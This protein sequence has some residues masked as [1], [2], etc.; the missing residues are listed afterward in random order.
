MRSRKHSTI[1]NILGLSYM[2]SILPFLKHV[3]GWKEQSHDWTNDEIAELYR[4][5]HAL[6]RANISVDTDRGITDEGDPWFVFCRRD[7]EVI[8]HIAR[9]D[10]LYHL[11]SPALPQPLEGPTFSALTRAFVASAPMAPN[12]AAASGVALHPAALLSLLV[13]SIFFSIDHLTG[14]PDRAQAAVVDRGHSPATPKAQYVQAILN[15]MVGAINPPEA[16]EVM[17]FSLFAGQVALAFVDFDLDEGGG[18]IAAGEGGAGEGGVRDAAFYHVDANELSSTSVAGANSTESSAPATPG[19]SLHSH[20][21]VLIAANAAT[22]GASSPPMIVGSSHAGGTVPL[23]IASAPPKFTLSSI[24]APEPITISVSSEV[25]IVHLTAAQAESKIQLSGHGAVVLA[26]LSGEASQTIEVTAG[27]QLTLSLN[28]SASTG[29]ASAPAQSASAVSTSTGSADSS[30]VGTNDA[31]AQTASGGSDAVVAVSAGAGAAD[32]SDAKTSDTI[33]QAAGSASGAHTSSHASAHTS[34]S[35]SAETVSQTL[36]LDGDDSVTL[37]SVS[38]DP[39]SA[40]N[41]TVESTG[42]ASN[43]LTVSDAA[44]QSTSLHL[45]IV[46]TQDV[47]VDESA[48]AL[49]SSSLDASALQ[50]RLTVGIDLSGV[51]DPTVLVGSSDFVVNPNGMVDLEN[52]PDQSSFQV[53][54]SLQTLVLQSAAGVSAIS[55]EIDLVNASNAT[56][57][58]TIGYAQMDTVTTLDLTVGGAVQDH[59][60]TLVDPALQTLEIQGVGSVT[61]GSVLGIGAAQ[62]QNLTIDAHQL[63]GG[64]YIDLSQIADT[65]AGGRHITVIGAQGGNVVTESN[66]AIVLTIQGGGGQDQFGIAA[67]AQAV[68]I[69]GWHAGDFLTVGVGQ[70]ADAVIDASHVSASSQATLDAASLTAAASMAA[71]QEGASVA[72]QAV[73]FMHSGNSYIFVDAAGDHQFNPTTDAIVQVVGVTEA[74]VFQNAIF[75]A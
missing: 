21:A 11:F 13:V 62:S 58:V 33:A 43:T 72:H 38:T 17:Q 48:N 45:T 5:E 4:V 61:V 55:V 36:Q 40:L 20:G 3:S 46:G 18:V 26:G 25:K 70:A 8:V 65:V 29:T 12:R 19:D 69:K 35:A 9:Y 7:G 51:S 50:A 64:L 39:G 10:G 32:N 57:P 23:P 30:D 67:G 56:S 6:C 16:D 63:V 68:T 42:A 1:N 53:G 47:V 71:T 60:G 28:F 24:G 75:S 74:S 59:I 34:V 66:P 73:F 2:A 22:I 37:A 49:N 27:S 15:A 14:Q 44:T 52:V 54:I 31:T 41:L